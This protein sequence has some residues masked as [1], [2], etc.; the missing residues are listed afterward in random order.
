M[1]ML[2]ACQGKGETL[3]GRRARGCRVNRGGGGM[4]TGIKTM[5]AHRLPLNLV[6]SIGPAPMRTESC[7]RTSLLAGAGGAALRTRCS[8]PSADTRTTVFNSATTA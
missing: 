5:G 2:G 6:T 3:T 4:H 7:S 8:D 1:R